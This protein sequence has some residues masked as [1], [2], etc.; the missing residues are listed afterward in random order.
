MRLWNFTRGYVKIKLE[1]YRPEQ[2]V[3]ILLAEGI[4]LHNTER[5]SLHEI[6]AVVSLK[7]YQLVCDSAQTYDYT[8]TVLAARGLPV[9]FKVL[10]SRPLLIFSIV[11]WLA[12]GIILPR[13]I[14]ILNI[15]GCDKVSES[16]ILTLMEN[17]GVKKG[18]PKSEIDCE[19]ISRA[20]LSYDKRISFADIRLHGVVLTAVIHETDAFKFSEKDDAPSSIYADKDCV[21]V[22]ITV[23]HGD[24]AVKPGQAVRRG[25]LLISG[26]ITP[27]R[28]NSETP[29]KIAAEGTVL[30]QTAYRFSVRI[31]RES[32]IYIR[33]GRKLPFTDIKFC[34]FDFHS[35]IPFPEYETEILQ[36]DIFTGSVLPLKI[37]SGCVYEIINAVSRLDDA[38]MTQLALK[39]ADALILKNI[40]KDARIIM[41]S[42]ELCWNKDGSLV[43]TVN[44]QAIEKIGY[45]R[46]I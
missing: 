21:I 10:M 43:M 6:H 34:G 1:C 37:E 46:Y 31:E 39:K 5:R 4:V 27:E 23:R 15:T 16:E 42:S 3:N 11:L 2:I 33:N 14:F 35:E 29:V 28:G 26:D 18:A 17:T 38:Q 13:R 7:D 25:E 22:K 9:W 40:P 30:A 44:I 12:A 41:R 36:T 19:K 20:I 32:E 24:S 45:S 8:V